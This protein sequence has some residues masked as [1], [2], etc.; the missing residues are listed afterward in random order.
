MNQ[1][2]KCIRDK[3]FNR[4]LKKMSKICRSLNEDFKMFEKVLLANIKKHED[5]LKMNIFQLKVWEISLNAKH[6]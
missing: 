6:L 2:C 3:K 1:I 4:E 5:V